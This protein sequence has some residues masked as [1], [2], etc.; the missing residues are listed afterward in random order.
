MNNS[1][2]NSTFVLY[3]NASSLL[4]HTNG[5]SKSVRLILEALATQECI[6]H[7]VMGCT[8][9]CKEG[10]KRNQSIWLEQGSTQSQKKLSRFTKNNVHYSLV[11]TEHWS[12]RYVAADEQ[13]LIYRESLDLI[14][15]AEQSFKKR[16]L[17]G[18]GNLL[19]EEAIFKH[20]KEHGF[21]IYFY[22]ANP[23]YKNKKV[24]TISL[25]TSI[26]TDSKATKTLYSS[27]F[28][29]EITV[30]P[31]CIEPPGPQ[32]PVEQ[33]WRKQSI[34][35]VNAK[36]RKGLEALIKIANSLQGKQPN[37]SIQIVDPGDH[38]D[39]SLKLLELTR[40]DLPENIKIVGGYPDAESLLA[41]ATC[42]LL[43][44]LW[45]ESGSRLIHECHLRGIP[46]LGFAT[47]GTTELLSQF[48]ADLFPRP[49]TRID[50]KGV[51]K[52]TSWNSQAIIERIIKLL[53]DFE[54]YKQHHQNIL[55]KSS[56]LYNNNSK[57]ANIILNTSAKF[58]N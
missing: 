52:I 25:S 21:Q 18:W 20:A 41:D 33:L 54:Y 29:T 45:H 7:A 43:L 56:H 36:L 57:A 55:N 2:N 28:K 39:E 40:D 53:C 26:L 4:D 38:L 16:I 5:A 1:E 12:R 27:D 3:T 14:E 37:I 32:K 50:H 51:I 10:F 31:K 42:L 9:D 24:P 19:L 46:V 23:S 13:E 8:S 58:R 49:L 30:L 22:L 17:I 15:I 11:A 6:V 47:G 34:V 44:S 48:D 35:F